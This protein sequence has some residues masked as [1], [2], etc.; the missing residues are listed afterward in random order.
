MTVV[1][2]SLL[3]TS[4]L[5][6]LTPSPLLLSQFCPLSSLTW[7]TLVPAW[8][9]ILLLRTLNCWAECS[10]IKH[11]HIMPLLNPAVAGVQGCIWQKRPSLAPPPPSLTTSDPTPCF[12]PLGSGITSLFHLSPHLPG[13]PSPLSGHGNSFSFRE[14]FLIPQAEVF[15][16]SHVLPVYLIPSSD[17]CMS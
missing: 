12:R 4:V 6:A 8:V 9:H 1:N 7:K 2:F 3:S 13:E 15:I 17:Y 11:V 16:P 5:K 10:K 14:G